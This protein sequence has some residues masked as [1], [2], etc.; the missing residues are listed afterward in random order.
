MVSGKAGFRKVAAKSSTLEGEEMCKEGMNA[1]T[2]HMDIKTNPRKIF[3]TD[4]VQ[5]SGRRG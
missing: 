5:K 1:I 4:A 2:K 3:T